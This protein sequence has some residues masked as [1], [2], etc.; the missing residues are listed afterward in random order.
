MSMPVEKLLD[1]L[2]QK[3]GTQP[4]GS[5]SGWAA[6]CPAHDDRRASL[7]IGVGDDGKVLVCCH[8][9]CERAAVIEAL[10]LDDVRLDAGS[11]VVAHWKTVA[12]IVAEYDYR[13][14]GG[15][16]LYQSVRFDPKG[17]C[18]RRRAKR[19]GSGSGK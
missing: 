15:M 17:F 1:A 16:L 11:G 2:H 10:G 8:A 9:K 4:K 7:S 6:R 14:E 13:D 19:M 12:Q 5:G 3:T 18:H